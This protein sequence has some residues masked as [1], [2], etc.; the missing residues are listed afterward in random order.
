MMLLPSSQAALQANLGALEQTRAELSVYKWPDWPVQDA[1]RRSPEVNLAPAVARYRQALAT[2]PANAVANRRLGQIELSR[3]EYEAALQHLEAAYAA[4]PGHRATRQL[5]GELYAM[6]GQPERARA[7]WQT[8]DLGLK[9][10][11][12]RAAWYKRL[13]EPERAAAIQAAATP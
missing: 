6:N 5:L 13:G 12:L 4:A 3:G 11:E 10:L 1:L 2:N 8:V 9:Q 7:L